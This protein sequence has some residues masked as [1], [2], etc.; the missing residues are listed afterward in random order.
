MLFR[1]DLR[2]ARDSGWFEFTV[3]V[4]RLTECFGLEGTFKGHLA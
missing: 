2:T 1:E 3:R 4:T